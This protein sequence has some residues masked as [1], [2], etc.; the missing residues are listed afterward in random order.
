MYKCTKNTYHLFC[1]HVSWNLTEFK[2]KKKKKKKFYSVNTHSCI[3][4]EIPLPNPVHARF[5]GGHLSIN[6]AVTDR[7]EPC[8][9]SHDSPLV[10]WDS[11]W[12]SLLWTIGKDLIWM[13]ICRDD[14]GG[15]QGKESVTL[16]LV[17]L[18]CGFTGSEISTTNGL[19]HL[20]TVLQNK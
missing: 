12:H 4:E 20:N 7:F 6:S 14:E 11:Y 8:P 17:V 16:G 5:Y 1:I 15:T 10:Q 9:L 2:K 3:D 18:S 19:Q 13:I